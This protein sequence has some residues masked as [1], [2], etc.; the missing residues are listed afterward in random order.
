MN[1]K[2]PKKPTAQQEKD[3]QYHTDIPVGQILRRARTQ[4]NLTLDDVG[5]ALRIRSSQ[6]GALEEGRNDQLPGRVYAIGFVRSYAE[7]LG[8]D[9]NKMVYLYKSQSAAPGKKPELHFP[10]PASESKAPNLAILAGSLAALILI[11]SIMAIFSGKVSYRSVIPSAQDESLLMAYTMVEMPMETAL[12]SV[13]AQTIEKK[14]L[15]SILRPQ[16]RIVITALN[17]VWMEIRTVDKRVLL[18]RII[19]KGDIYTVP[20]APGLV[21]DTGNIG[22]L[23]F[24]VDGK[25]IP[26][27][28]TE[29]D[30]KR[31]LALDADALKTTAAQIVPPQLEETE[32]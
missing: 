3:F 32:E 26:A 22:A 12:N 29:G 17:S 15:E 4:Y 19:K 27:L 20:N 10:A 23:S 13:I 7:Y 31:G 9:G 21:L 25:Q 28:G 5:K 18:S 24:T 1:E 14:G 8:L 30:V 16:S 2:A 11:V 6:L